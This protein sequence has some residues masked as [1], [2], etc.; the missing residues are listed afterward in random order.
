MSAT[1]ANIVRLHIDEDM[2]LRQWTCK[3]CTKEKEEAG[4]S[5]NNKVYSTRGGTSN[6]VRHFEDHHNELFQSALA[7]FHKATPK[8]EKDSIKHHFARS[9]VGH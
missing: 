1:K 9:Q 7:V 6:I 3:Q 8:K 4:R 5:P 2:I